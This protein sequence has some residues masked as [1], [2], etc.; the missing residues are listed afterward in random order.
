MKMEADPSCNVQP[1][2]FDLFRLTTNCERIAPFYTYWL[3]P[4]GATGMAAYF[5]IYLGC[6]SIVQSVQL[7]NSYNMEFSERSQAN[8][9]QKLD[10]F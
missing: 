4:L 2:E 6:R 5:D 10:L 7:R 9:M 3:G 8:T 1:Y